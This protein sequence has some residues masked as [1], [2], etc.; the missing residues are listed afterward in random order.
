M[1]FE[2]KI[3][4][5]SSA[6]PSP[7][8]HHTA[9]VLT[10]GNQINL[11][12]CGENAQ[13]QLMRYKVKHQRISNIFISHLHGDH[14]FGLFGLLSTMHLQHRTLPLQLFGP[15]GLDEILTTQ[16]RYSNT[17]LSF[18]LIFHE[19]DT[20]VH[21]LVYEDKAITVH[22]LPMQHRVPC[23]GFL[24][25]EKPKLRHLVKDKLP[26]FLTPPQLIRLKQGQDIF[27]EN[28]ELL[29]ANLDVTR[30][31]N[32][33]RSY[34]YCSDTKYKEDILPYIQHVDL[35]YH[36]ATFLDELQHQAA[37]TLHS[38]ARQAA[39]LALKAEVKRLLIG[40]FSVR[41]RDLNPL[42][43]EAQ[44]VFANTQLALEGKTIQVLE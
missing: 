13:M 41:Y 22:T 18:K 2:L 39:T 16:L 14:Y 19:L 10:I 29:V 31:P 6:T 3:L 32:H 28:G 40:H 20:T 37:Y 38:T 7:D 5:S 42:L 17:Q 12:D 23:C 4:G 24:F 33:S 15:A 25:R 34:A 36:E 8:R 43:E 26:A 11:I 1:D 44:V 27:N 30:E 35:L 9:Q 21:A